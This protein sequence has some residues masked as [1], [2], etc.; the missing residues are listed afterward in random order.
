MG[1]EFWKLKLGCLGWL[2]K[3]RQENTYLAQS[4]SA[5]SIKIT[6][7][8]LT[9]WILTADLGRNVLQQIDFSLEYVL[10]AIQT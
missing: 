3:Y 9:K 2:Q 1:R 4:F 5:N 8:R 6:H 10:R 7:F